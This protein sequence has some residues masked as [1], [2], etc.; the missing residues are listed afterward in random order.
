MNL[1]ELFDLKEKLETR[2]NR[3]WTYWSVA[4]LAIAGWVFAGDIDNIIQ[5]ILIVIGATTFFISNLTVLWTA[6]KLVIGL[7]DEIKLKSITHEIKSDKLR[8]NIQ[9]TNSKNRM[10]ITW[11]LHIV[12]DISVIVLV[13]LA[14]CFK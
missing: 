8:D 6:T 1:I 3:Y 5:R 11:I 13:L 12:V 7:Q 10:K 9:N 2:I 14:K 4:I